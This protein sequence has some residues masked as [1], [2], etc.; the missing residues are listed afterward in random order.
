MYIYFACIQDVTKIGGET[1]WGGGNVLGG[2]DSGGE[3][4]RVMGGEMTKGKNRGEMTWVGGCGKHL[5][6]ETTCYPGKLAYF[7]K[8]INIFFLEHQ[9]FES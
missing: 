8:I 3:R 2:N 7:T 9:I 5:G 6:G 1:T 4:T